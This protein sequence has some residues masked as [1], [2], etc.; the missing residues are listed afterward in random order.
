MSNQ[1]GSSTDFDVSPIQG[2]GT[3][4]RVIST[5]SSGP[6]PPQ[7]EAIQKPL[8]A[9]GQDGNRGNPNPN[10]TL[11]PRSNPKDTRTPPI[12]HTALTNHYIS[13]NYTEC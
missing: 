5:Q 12:I 4:K 2:E 7:P 6:I 3:R 9:Q 10:L 8:E 1:Q 13:C 11:K